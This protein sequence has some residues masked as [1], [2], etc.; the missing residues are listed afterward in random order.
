MRSITHARYVLALSAGEVTGEIRA[1]Y[2]EDMKIDE[3]GAPL[4]GVILSTTV[5][6]AMDKQMTAEEAKRLTRE[7][8]A[9][10]KLEETLGDYSAYEPLM[11]V[12]FGEPAPRSQ[13]LEYCKRLTNAAKGVDRA[14]KDGVYLGVVSALSAVWMVLQDI[15]YAREVTDYAANADDTVYGAEIFR[16]LT[17]TVLTAQTAEES[18]QQ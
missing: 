3:K 6:A 18:T 4:L 1:A 8:Y 7:E 14:V 10:W 5:K 11:D 9:A 12:L 16:T 15:A 17:E 2:L 13:R